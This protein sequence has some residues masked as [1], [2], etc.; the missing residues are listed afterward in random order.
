MLDKQ[1]LEKQR[2]T[3]G[4][5]VA[6]AFTLGI[7]VFSAGRSTGGDKSSTE[8]QLSN[9]SASITELKNDIKNNQTA[10]NIKIDNL[11]TKLNALTSEVAVLK[12]K[13]DDKQD[14]PR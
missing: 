11:D 13:V 8:L 1:P 12:S 2:V 3:V 10:Q 4:V 14:R 6:A 5:A 7:L 9:I